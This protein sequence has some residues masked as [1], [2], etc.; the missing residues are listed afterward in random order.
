MQNTMAAPTART[1]DASPTYASDDE[2]TYLLQT[3]LRSVPADLLGSKGS[4]FPLL[5][6]LPARYASLGHVPGRQVVFVAAAT[7]RTADERRT[8]EYLL[9]NRSA[10][11]QN[12]RSARSLL[13]AAR[14]A[15]E[16]DVRRV[17]LV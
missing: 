16:M 3:L 9:R 12:E 6:A 1:I 7:H 8:A 5:G 2:S 14:C 17:R 15:A 13:M 10:V 11:G 4:G